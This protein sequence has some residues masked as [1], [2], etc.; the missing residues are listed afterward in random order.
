MVGNR[1]PSQDEVLVAC[2]WRKEEEELTL[3]LVLP[4]LQIKVKCWISDREYSRLDDL[5][6]V[7]KWS[8]AA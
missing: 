2:G 8:I 3:I 1:P 6:A 4:F 5:K 7:P